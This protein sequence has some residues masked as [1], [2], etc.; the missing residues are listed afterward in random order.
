[1]QPEVNAGARS[2]PYLQAVYVLAAP[3]APELPVQMLVRRAWA[4]LIVLVGVLFLFDFKHMRHA[5]PV[6]DLHELESHSQ[7]KGRGA[8]SAAK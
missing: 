7:C 5:G 2:L 1:M 8:E 4:P 3:N 6:E